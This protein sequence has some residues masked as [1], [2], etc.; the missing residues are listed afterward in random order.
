MSRGEQSSESPGRRHWQPHILHIQLV[1]CLHVCEI[2]SQ[3]AG[4]AVCEP[5]M[6]IPMEKL[7]LC[8]LRISE[9]LMGASSKKLALNGVV[10]P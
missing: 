7:A 9:K 6:G 3:F 5:L 2:V 10:L 8:Y 4:K 1:L